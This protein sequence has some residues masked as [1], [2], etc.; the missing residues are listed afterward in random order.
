M[1]HLEIVPHQIWRSKRSNFQIYIYKKKGDKWL[2][3]VLTEKPDVY[4][5]THTMNRVT[6]LKRYNL[7]Q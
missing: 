5:G 7:I 2:V 3:K 1:Q 6:I 4:N